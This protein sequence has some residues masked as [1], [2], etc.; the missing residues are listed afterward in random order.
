MAL[1]AITSQQ[2]MLYDNDTYEDFGVFNS[3]FTLMMWVMFGQVLGI[4]WQNIW[5]ANAD[6]NYEQCALDSDNTFSPDLSGNRVAGTIIAQANVWYHF[7]EVRSSTSD[8]RWYVDGVL[9]GTNTYPVDTWV[10]P[11]E[12]AI[13]TSS[14]GESTNVRIAHI[15]IWQRALSLQEIHAEMYK[16][17]PQVHDNLRWYFPCYGPNA[18]DLI[19]DMSGMGGNAWT[20]VGL[21]TSTVDPPITMG[22]PIFYIPP[23]ETSGVDATSSRPGFTVGVATTQSSR[24]AYTVGGLSANS[25]RPGFLLGNGSASASQPGFT[26]GSEDTQSSIQA[27][28]EGVAGTDVSSSLAAFTAGQTQYALRPDGDIVDGVW[29]DQAS[30]SDLYAAMDEPSW[31][32][33]D[34][35]W[36]EHAQAGDSF[37][38]SLSDPGFTPDT[39]AH[40]VRWRAAR[41]ANTETVTVKCELVQGTTVI[42]SDQQVLTGSFQTF[43]YSLSAPEIANITNYNDLRL[44]F[45][46]VS[47]T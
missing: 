35:V 25:S 21:T 41:I 11:R 31:I 2:N 14:W 18:S 15:K 33:T 1:S 29:K 30:G 39:G 28:T 37:E 34:Y 42:A 44:R 17:R 24:A 6:S 9:D 3:N 27:Y 12:I 10:E 46:I 13:G 36:D 47:I 4:Q 45:T 26:R 38:V 23:I 19:R 16:A 20:Q 22:A 43:E 8:L 40:I 5:N 32:D 7:A